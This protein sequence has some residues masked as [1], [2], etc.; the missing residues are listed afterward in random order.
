MNWLAFDTS[1]EQASIAVFAAEK[2]HTAIEPNLR[3][4]ARHL[5]PII[6]Q[7]LQDAA[8]T[9]SELNG[10]IFGCGPG[11]FTGLR[12]ACSVAQGL[13]YAT[14]LPLYPVNSLHAIANSVLKQKNTS[15]LTILDARM[16]EFYWACYSDSCHFEESQVS[17]AEKIRIKH[18]GDLI[19]A[20]VGLQACI[21]QLH[22]AIQSRIVDS[23]EQYPCAESMIHMVQSGIVASVL[24]EKAL[25][26]YVR[27]HV[28]Q[29]S[30]HG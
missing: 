21:E 14:G 22:P 10:I 28:T 12:I 27:H 13:S 29:G 8:M 20:G 2:M 18:D 16:Q 9:L 24:S 17:F 25:P 23:F 30:S 6:H 5:L 11:S 15:V 19:L 26:T 1:T 7:L 3:Q 4:H